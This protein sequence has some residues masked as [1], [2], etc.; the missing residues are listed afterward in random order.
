MFLDNIASYG[1]GIEIVVANTEKSTFTE[2]VKAV[3][4]EIKEKQE[5]AIESTVE[6]FVEQGEAYVQEVH[7]SALSTP[8]RR[9]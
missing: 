4:Q 3:T 7:E 8:K 2:D 9:I 1:Y 6:T 5:K